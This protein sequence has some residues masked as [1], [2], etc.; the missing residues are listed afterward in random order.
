MSKKRFVQNISMFYNGDLGMRPNADCIAFTSNIMAE[1]GYDSVIAS[2]NI[3][4]IDPKKDARNNLVKDV[5][6]VYFKN[7]LDYFR[8]IRKEK[9]SIVF[10][11]DRTIVGLTACFFGRYRLL[12]SHQSQN[13]PV[14]W[15]K[16]IFK[17]FAKRFDAIKVANPYEKEELIKLGV[18]PK[19]IFY[20]PIP[21]DYPFFGKEVPVEEKAQLREKY[22][23]K[24]DDFVIV[25]PSSFR[26]QKHP[27]IAL[28]AL[29]K[30]K[31]KHKDIKMVFIGKDK[32]E[33]EGLKNIP[34]QA[35][36]LGISEYMITT[37]FVSEEELRALMQMGDIGVQCSTREGQCLTVY[38]M[39][40]A[41]LPF[42]LS[43]IGSF[44]SVFSDS[45]FFHQPFDPDIL[46]KNIE[47][48]MKNPDIAKKHA[49]TN[50]RIVKERCDYDVLKG[51]LKS[52]LIDKQ[53]GLARGKSF[54]ARLLNIC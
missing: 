12:M 44:N 54:I 29:K 4:G 15:Q 21:I 6:I 16:A 46:A 1:G 22:G 19:R 47:Y 28:K 42:C 11:N 40:S 14:W 49:E 24:D 13:P 33:K 38:D 31:E 23:I 3:L 37:G 8:F 20:I 2:I 10:G 53:Q 43:N 36:E 35:K 27:E 45:A 50:R 18:D 51:K 17:F 39:A 25:I 34:E 26:S 5:K 41:G 30:L 52:L 48:Y 7:L 9:D 32:L